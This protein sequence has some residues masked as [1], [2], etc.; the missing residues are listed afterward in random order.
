MWGVNCNMLRLKERRRFQNLLSQ[1]LRA[2]VTEIGNRDPEKRVE[3][4][5][6]FRGNRVGVGFEQILVPL[7]VWPLTSVLSTPTRTHHTSSAPRW[8][9]V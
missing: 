8:E 5:R 7:S 3:R 4:E 1:V 2:L 6:K 9:G